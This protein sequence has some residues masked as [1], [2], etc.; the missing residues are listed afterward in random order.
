MTFL[1]SRRRSSRSSVRASTRR[2][3]RPPRAPV[4][5]IQAV[6]R[7]RLLLLPVFILL[8]AAAPADA[9]TTVRQASGAP[10]AAIQSAIDQFRADLGQDNQ[11]DDPAESGR[12]EI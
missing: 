7:P 2:W 8:G 11:A 5:S 12:R 3:R 4:R 10:P 6:P 1:R 9:A